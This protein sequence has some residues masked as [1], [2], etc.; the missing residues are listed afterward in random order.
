MLDMRRRQ[1][2]SVLAGAAAAW[3]H[4]GRA[5]RAGARTPRIGIIDDAPIWDHFRQGLRDLGY[6][7]GQNIA[8]EY[9]S[10]EGDF[11]RLRLAALELALLPVNVMV[12]YG[13]PAT[14]AARQATSKIPIVMIGIGDP[15]R[16]RFVTNLAHPNGNITGNILLRLALH[17]PGGPAHRLS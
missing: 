14:R 8:I 9:R 12:V 6:V 13:S 2:I 17:Y 7:E 5:Q 3:P 15:V 16:A 1:F 11:D 10:A 4:A